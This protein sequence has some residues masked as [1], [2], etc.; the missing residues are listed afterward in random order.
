VHAQDAKEGAMAKEGA[1]RAGENTQGA[2]RKHRARHPADPL[3]SI[4]V[5]VLRALLSERSW[6]P[7]EL[8]REA[9]D[10]QQTMSSLLAGAATH[11]RC[12]RARAKRIAEVLRIPLELLT[13]GALAL[14]G[15]PAVNPGYEY[16][17]SARTELA[18]SRL[19]TR[20]ASALRRDQARQPKSVRRYPDVLLRE[21]AMTLLAELV[22]VGE[23]RRRLLR[24]KPGEWERRGSAEPPIAGWAGSVELREVKP[25]RDPEH[26]AAILGLLRAVE[27]ILT[28]WFDDKAYLNF[29][30]V[31]DFG[32]FHRTGPLPIAETATNPADVLEDPPE[33]LEAGRSDK[34]PATK[35]RKT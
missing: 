2:K 32:R 27:H 22:Q 24:W 18:A 31:R 17:Y 1:G 21:T 34:T 16:R 9:E 35:R 20:I 8:A 3:V 26:E 29:A 28:P 19:M 30:A 11:K 6:G 14:P 12:R 25:Q 33:E 15:G 13:G 4:N 5:E 7:S 23:W 10:T